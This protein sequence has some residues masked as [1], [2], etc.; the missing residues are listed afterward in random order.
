[1][2]AKTSAPKPQEFRVVIYEDKDGAPGALIAT[3]KVTAWRS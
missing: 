3:R 2:T 1:M